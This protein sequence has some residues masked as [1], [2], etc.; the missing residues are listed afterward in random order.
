LDYEPI[1]FPFKESPHVNM[2]Y[3]GAA[4]LAA[5]MVAPVIA[6][7]GAKA[8]KKGNRGQRANATTQLLKQL[9]PVALTDEQV[10]KIKELGK[11]AVVKMKEARDKAGIT[12][13]VTKKRAAAAKS[14]KDSGKNRKEM[15]AAI[16]KAAG[17]T[18]AQIAGWASVTES[19][20]KFYKDAIALLSDEQKEKLPK[21]LQRAANAG[22]KGARKKKKDAA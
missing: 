15:Q 3:V 21:Q 13:E 4:L 11:V 2:K 5:L 17:L 20:R 8:K 18:E 9:E 19:R 1:N 10:A 22:K 12:A 14:L 6:Q 16:N 7:D